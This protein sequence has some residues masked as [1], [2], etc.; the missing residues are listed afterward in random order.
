MKGRR[1]LF[2]RLIALGIW[3]LVLAFP[4]WFFFD[5]AAAAD[6]CEIVKVLFYEREQREIVTDLD[7]VI[8][9]RR[10]QTV[11]YPCAALTIRDNSRLMHRKE[12]EVTATFAD[13]QTG[14][15][16]AW[17]DRKTGDEGEI[18]SCI[19]CFENASLITKVSCIF[20]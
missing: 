1:L 5:R 6:E 4:Y 13:G 2:H 15:K 16:R 17:C 8:P 12:I 18:Y 9:H 11:T 7:S 10:Y 3:S 19:V 14:V 20:E